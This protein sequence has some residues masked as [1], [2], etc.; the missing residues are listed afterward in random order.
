MRDRLFRLATPLM[1]GLFVVSLLSG[2]VIFFHVGPGWFHPAHEWLSMLLIIPFGLH[3][4]RNWRPFVNYFKKALMPLAVAASLVA[5]AV[6]GLAPSGEA[7]ARSGPPQFAL[8]D[9]I[10]AATPQVAAPVLGTTPDELVAKLKAAGIA[11]ADAGVS[12]KTAAIAAG[13]STTE[14]YQ[15]ILTA[16]K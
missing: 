8:A 7:S 6:F 9:S 10:I 5:L 13:K 3:L 4:W 1:T 14:L 16:D 12:M 15:V 11:N 2:V